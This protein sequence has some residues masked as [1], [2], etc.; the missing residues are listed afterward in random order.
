MP[1]YFRNNYKKFHLE[2]KT[3]YGFRKCQLGA[4]WATKSHFTK[5][6]EPALIS[7]PTGSGKTALMMSLSFELKAQ[8]VL[9]ITPSKVI[10]DQISN[11]FSTLQIL[12]DINVLPQSF[13]SLPDVKT[14][15]KICNSTKKWD[16]LINNF[17]IVIGTPKT[18]SP[19]EKNV[20]AP[21]DQSFDLVIFDEAHHAPAKTWNSLITTFN[22]SKVVL[23]TATPFRRDK[24]RIRA[25]LVYHYSI[26]N[27]IKENIYRIVDFI[28]VNTSLNE[29]QKDELL[30]QETLARFESERKNDS[31]TS[32]LIKTD[33]IEHSESLKILYHGL[34]LN[35]DTI[36]TEKT[37]TENNIAITKCKNNSLDGI[38]CVGMVGEG[39]DIPHLKIAVLHTVPRTL[40]FTIQFIGRVSR[41]NNQ[42]QGNALL[43]AD[44]NYVKGEVRKLYKYDKG[45]HELIP[46]L[47]DRTVSNST[48]TNDLPNDLLNRFDLNSDEIEP[49]YSTRIYKTTNQFEFIDSFASN[50]KS[51]VELILIEQKNDKEPLII[52]SKIESQPAWG[53]NLALFQGKYDLHFF[54]KK[55]GFLF[56]YTTSD[57]ICNK[58]KKVLIKK[59]SISRVNYNIIRKGLSDAK[60]NKYFMIGLANSSGVGKS[61]PKYKMYLGKEVQAS[62]R[63]SDGSSFTAGHALTKVSDQETRGIALQN[64]R[65]WAIKRETIHNYRQWCNSIYNLIK[66]SKEAS[67]PQMEMLAN[68][69]IIKTIDEEPAAIIFDDSLFDSAITI[70]EVNGHSINNPTPIIEFKS[71]SENN[72]SI[73]CNLII[74]KHVAEIELI[75]EINKPECWKINSQFNVNVFI[76]T[77]NNDPYK[78]SLKNYLNDHPPLIIFPSGNSLKKNLLIIPKISS[79]RFPSELIEVKEWGNIDIRR[80]SRPA[81]NGYEFNIQDKCIDLI[82]EFSKPDDFIIIDDRANEIADVIRISPVEKS[83][84]FYHCKFKVS[85]SKTPGANLSDIKEL[86]EQGI[87]NG[88]WIFSS[89]LIDRLID[90]IEGNSELRTGTI[91]DLRV[92]NNHFQVTQ[93]NYNVILVQPGLSKYSVLPKSRKSNIEKLLV[94]LLDRT[95]TINAQLSIW[96]SK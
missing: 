76:D 47:V 17:D 52:I 89:N 83:I 48:L 34:G 20:I 31:N 18:L 24:K 79:V 82:N 80:E 90:R 9:I 84:E 26:A 94:A 16:D 72:K 95:N 7:M 4:T 44:P 33:T 74:D 19:A 71:K 6:S 57:F 96:M 36:H 92:L 75:F 29:S 93:W 88:H 14:N 86:F 61:N 54:Y 60:G 42:Q 43:I 46:S 70:I 69:Q 1:D 25:E 85:P 11:E 73:R 41:V 62:L 91:D 21:P 67:I 53:K 8:R 56:E 49:F 3:G 39:L 10:R 66:Q 15:K 68:T 45:W 13:N 28:S 63:L 27:A 23:L 22:R 2:P 81:R 40:P 55:G 32:V 59:D 58:I 38:I 37:D 65:I 50:L 35:V 12:Y 77:G 51:D 64:S 78:A 87:R 30:G 5:S